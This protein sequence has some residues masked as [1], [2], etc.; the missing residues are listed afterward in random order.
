MEDLKFRNPKEFDNIK[1]IIFNSAE[2]YGEN[3]AFVIKT[4]EDGKVNYTNI[5]YKKLLEDINAL[6]TALYNLGFK[7][8]RIAIIGKNRYEWVLSHLANVMGG[9]VSIPLDKDLQLEELE[10]SLVRSKADA[11]VYDDKLEEFMQEIKQRNNTNVKDYICM[12]GKIA[13]LIDRGNELIKKRRKRICK[14]QSR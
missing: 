8:K 6:G 11:I 5:S 13:E 1:E 4:K 12:T 2:E 9:I 10:N 3:T 14:L 7:G